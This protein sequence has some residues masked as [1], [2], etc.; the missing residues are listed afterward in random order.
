MVTEALGARK[1]QMAYYDQ[2]VE[3]PD[4]AL[5]DIA[6]RRNL[7]P[8]ELLARIGDIYA[9]ARSGKHLSFGDAKRWREAPE[10]A[11]GD[12]RSHI[13]SCRYCQ[14]L[15]DGLAPGRLRENVVRLQT[16]MAR[17]GTARFFSRLGESVGQWIHSYGIPVGAALAAGFAAALV[18]VPNA[19]NHR[20]LLDRTGSLSSPAFAANVTGTSDIG[21]VV[22]ASCNLLRTGGDSTTILC[23]KP[24]S[25]RNLRVQIAS[26][27]DDGHWTVTSALAG[28]QGREASPTA[29]EGRQPFF[30]HDA[31]RP[32]DEV[33]VFKPRSSQSGD[34]VKAVVDSLAALKESVNVSSK[35]GFSAGAPVPQ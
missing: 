31:L 14:A 28:L 5:K 22:S 15:L 16:E 21:G 24:R 20:T 19:F 35:R 30:A 23:F 10:G 4:A 17:H 1:G 11:P 34:S 8:E 26:D 33:L 32:G 29:V 13:D 12:L 6:A 7:S 9:E 2:L 3:N 25:E 18:V 27:G